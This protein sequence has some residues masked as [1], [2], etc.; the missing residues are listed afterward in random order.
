MRRYMLGL[1]IVTVVAAGAGIGFMNTGVIAKERPAP[2]VIVADS[3]DTASPSDSAPS[4]TKPTQVVQ[5]QLAQAQAKA[6]TQVAQAAEKND[7]L[8]E[9]VLGDPNAPITIL[10]YS[11]LTCPHCASFHANTLPQLKKDFI[12]TGKVKLVFRD[13]PFD[14]AALQ[15]SM[16]ARCSNPERYF[17]FLDVLFKSQ[18]KWAGASDPAQ[19]LAQTGKLAGVGDQQFKECLAN[20]ALANKLIERRLEA[21]QK[22][23]VQSTPTFVIMRGDTIEKVVGAQPIAE[24]ARVIDKLGS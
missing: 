14:R 2:E 23:Q 4:T 8:S 13:F 21:E 11:S 15:A 6:S 12:D 3:V 22:Y 1:A 19:A 10:E 17:G 9:R 5:A 20:E 24:F 18:N 7:P 16:L